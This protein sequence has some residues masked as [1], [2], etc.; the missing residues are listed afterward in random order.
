MHLEADNALLSLMR[1]LLTILL[2]FTASI[3]SLCVFK[4]MS[5]INPRAVLFSFLSTSCVTQSGSASVSVSSFASRVM[6]MVVPS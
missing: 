4:V 6:I 1:I 3:Y 2:I 5:L